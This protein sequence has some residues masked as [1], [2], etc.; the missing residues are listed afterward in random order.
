M[1]S[2]ITATSI[3]TKTLLL[4]TATL[5]ITT[6]YLP[7]VSTLPPDKTIFFDNF[8]NGNLGWQPIIPAGGQASITNGEYRLYHAKPLQFLAAIAPPTTSQ[9]SINGYVIEANVKLLQG[10]ECKIGFIFDWKDTTNY[11]LFVIKPVTQEYW[12]YRYEQG[13]YHVILSGYSP[14]IYSEMGV[15]NHLKLERRA[16]SI[17]AYI[18]GVL[19]GGSVQDPMAINGRVGLQLLVYNSAPGEGR[20][21]NFRLSDLP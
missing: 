3:A 6:T 15:A 2:T 16:D 4:P 20:Y 19:L 7:F 21:D 5:A 11:Q 17:S 1:A 12:V 18:N 9:I 13:I 14:V 10:A 8:S